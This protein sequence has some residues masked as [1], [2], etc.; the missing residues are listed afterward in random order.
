MLLFFNFAPL[1]TY[2]FFPVIKSLFLKLCYIQFRSNLC[3]CRDKSSP[4]L[5]YCKFKGHYLPPCASPLLAPLNF[6]FK[7]FNRATFTTYYSKKASAKFTLN[8]VLIPMLNANFCYIKIFYQFIAFITSVSLKKLSGRDIILKYY[9]P[10]S[11][12]RLRNTTFRPVL[13]YFFKL[14]A[15]FEKFQ[16]L[17]EHLDQV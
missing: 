5:L 11:L 10:T 4:I 2:C 15:H 6:P 9:R 8:G 1:L 13:R 17:A 7:N 12:K 16:K 14:V 3:K